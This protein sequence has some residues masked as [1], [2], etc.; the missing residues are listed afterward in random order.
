[1]WVFQNPPQQPTVC[2]AMPDPQGTGGGKKK[3]KGFSDSSASQM[4]VC[5]FKP[6]NNRLI[7]HVKIRMHRKCM[8]QF[9]TS[10]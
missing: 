4:S 9:R 5:G 6:E 10:H 1:M 8:V 7:S 3:K 2:T